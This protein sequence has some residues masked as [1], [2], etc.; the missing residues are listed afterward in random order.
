MAE[1]YYVGFVDCDG[2]VTGILGIYKTMSDLKKACK[3]LYK[4]FWAE[5]PHGNKRSVCKR[6]GLSFEDGNIWVNSEIKCFVGHYLS[7]V[8]HYEWRHHKES[9][10]YYDQIEVGENYYADRWIVDEE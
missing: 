10:G 2:F 4:Q 5:H 9:V 8:G 6:K 3:P 1:K 7:K